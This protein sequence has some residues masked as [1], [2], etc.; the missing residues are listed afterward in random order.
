MVRLPKTEKS[1]PDAETKLNQA[2]HEVHDTK[3]A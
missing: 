2:Q 3:A 1:K